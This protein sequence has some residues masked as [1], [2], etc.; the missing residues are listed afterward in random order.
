VPNQHR[1]PTLSWHPPV[2]LSRW[3]RSEAVRRGVALKVIL[4]EAL[5]DLRAKFEQA[6]K[7]AKS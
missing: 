4:D 3:A 7:E 5:A 6:D 1:N 2:E